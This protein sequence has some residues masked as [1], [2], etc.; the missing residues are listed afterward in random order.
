MD[1]VVVRTED[2]PAAIGAYSQGIVAGGFVYTSGQ[3]GMRRE[4]DAWVLDGD[5][6]EQTERCLRYVAAVL[7]AGGSDLSRVVKV[8]VFLQDMAGFATM[9]GVYERRFAEALGG[10]PF[11][12]RSAVQAAALPRGA[13]VEIEAI[14]L[15]G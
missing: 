12:A 6:A 2:A 8:T 7:R 4:G 9:N 1:R 3:I 15:V 10:A 13:L 5:L 11:P 14:G